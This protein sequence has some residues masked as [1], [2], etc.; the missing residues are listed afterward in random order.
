MN[1]M[2]YESGIGLGF[3]IMDWW[4]MKQINTPSS[5]LRING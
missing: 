3:K 4:M 1:N 2:G 5:M